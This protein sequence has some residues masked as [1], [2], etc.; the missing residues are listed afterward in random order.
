MICTETRPAAEFETCSKYE[1]AEM[2]LGG[3]IQLERSIA[4]LE[5]DNDKI[6][7]LASALRA[8]GSPSWGTGASKYVSPGYL[9]PLEYMARTQ[10]HEAPTVAALQAYVQEISN[11]LASLSGNRNELPSL[12]DACLALHESLVQ[13]LLLEAA[14]FIDRQD[15]ACVFAACVG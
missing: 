2:A 10:Q 13:E 11:A 5:P 6:Q 3:A 8:V 14:P 1:L 15:S 9:A 7:R 12:R 4:G